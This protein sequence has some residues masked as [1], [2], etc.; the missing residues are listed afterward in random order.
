MTR[1]FQN[2]PQVP[3]ALCCST[4][5]DAIKYVFNSNIE[6][7]REKQKQELKQIKTLSLLI[8]ACLVDEN[9]ISKFVEMQLVHTR[10]NRL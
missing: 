10:Q 5:G 2:F 6:S 7:R 4:W 8:A 9:T 3:E 1:E